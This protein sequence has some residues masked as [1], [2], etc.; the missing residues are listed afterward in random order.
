MSR[1]TGEIRR[2]IATSRLFMTGTGDNCPGCR[3]RAVPHPIASQFM[4]SVQDHWQVVLDVPNGRRGGS[5]AGQ[6]HG[7]ASRSGRCLKNDPSVRRK[8]ARRSLLINA[9]QWSNTAFPQVNRLQP[10]VPTLTNQA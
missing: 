7:L 2:T 3:N 6:F 4:Q 5:T 1:Q 10:T 9:P 8:S